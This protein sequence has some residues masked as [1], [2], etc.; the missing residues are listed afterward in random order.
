MFFPANLGGVKKHTN[1][2][3]SSPMSS[4]VHSAMH[5]KL[6]LNGYILYY[7]YYNIFSFNTT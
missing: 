4:V 7:I 2:T 3:I 1:I 5:F 6:K